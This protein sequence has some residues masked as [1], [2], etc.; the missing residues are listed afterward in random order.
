MD[1]GAAR[2]VASGRAS[3]LAAGVTAIDDNLNASD[4][5]SIVDPEGKE[6]ARGLVAFDS[7]HVREMIGKSTDEIA[8]ELGEDYGRAVVH[9]DDLVLVGRS[10]GNPG[11]L[12]D[13]EQ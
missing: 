6:I 5:V 13:L 10:R 2:A 7:S 12:D 9:L 3:L 1:E 4:P 11:P 8:N